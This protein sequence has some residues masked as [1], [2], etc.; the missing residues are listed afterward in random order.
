MAGL[1]QC[2]AEM[3][4]ARIFNEKKGNNIPVIYGTV[5][6]GIFWKFIKIRDNQIYIDLK[7]YS[8][9]DNPHKIIG[10]LSS[11]MKQEI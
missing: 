2:L 8:I 11:M 6:T 1:G 5:T 7:D 4:A 3:I 10:I 9:I